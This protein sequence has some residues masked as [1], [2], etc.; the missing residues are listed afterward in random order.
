MLY[1]MYTYQPG[2][3]R[4]LLQMIDEQINLINIKADPVVSILPS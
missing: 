1:T 3:I 2:A 4:A